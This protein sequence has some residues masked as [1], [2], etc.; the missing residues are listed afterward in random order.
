MDLTVKLDDIQALL[1]LAN[2]APKSRGETLF[3]QMFADKLNQQLPAEPPHPAET[4][5]A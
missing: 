4:P 1:E 2:R 3:L 5:P